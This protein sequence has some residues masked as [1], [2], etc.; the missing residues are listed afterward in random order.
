MSIEKGKLEYGQC[1]TCH[2]IYGHGNASIRAPVI[3]G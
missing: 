1:I 3:A 2:G